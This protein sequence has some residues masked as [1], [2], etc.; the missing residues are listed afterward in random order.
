M[1]QGFLHEPASI[2]VM[3]CKVRLSNLVKSK[4]QGATGSAHN[5]SGLN[6][7]RKKMKKGTPRKTNMF[8]KRDYFSREYIFQPLIFRGHE[9]VSF[10]EEE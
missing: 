6:Y 4:L 7:P 2:G 5:G 10:Q 1:K 9:P 3:E 8:P